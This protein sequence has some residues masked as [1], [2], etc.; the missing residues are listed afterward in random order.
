MEKPKSRKRLNALQ[1]DILLALYK[2]R[3]VTRDLIIE[4]Q[5]HKS[6]T[7]TYYRLENLVEQS[8][9]GRKFDNFDKISRRPVVYYIL[10]K[11][12]GSLKQQPNLNKSVINTM[13]KD[14]GTSQ[15]FIDRCL[16]IFDI[17]N[18]LNQLYG[19]RLNFYSKSELSEYDYFLK[20]LSD[21]Y[22]TIE[23]KK[24]SSQHFLLELLSSDKPVFAHRKRIEHHL[25]HYE[26]GDWEEIGEEYPLL[27]LVCETSRLERRLQ[28][29][30][31][32]LFD[33]RGVEEVSVFTTTTK[34]LLSAQSTREPIWSD[35]CDPEELITI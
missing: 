13:Y 17:Y 1:K 21:A 9:I 24:T 11:G 25:D 32:N 34:A 2:F 19:N 15:E 18:K 23:N 35:V 8:Y 30:I 10:P 14:R 5:G 12:I 3:F 4:Y 31:A 22:F 28:Q 33:R 16:T 20:P 26:F 27:L 7:Y 6:K 29:V